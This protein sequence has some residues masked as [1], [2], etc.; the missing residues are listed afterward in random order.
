MRLLSAVCAVAL[1]AGLARA[2]EIPPTQLASLGWAMSASSGAVSS[3]GGAGPGGGLSG[4]L[5]VY[6]GCTAP[7]AA[8]DSYL[9]SK[10]WYFDVANGHPP[11]YYA[12]LAVPQAQ[13]GDVN[14]PFDNPNAIW[15]QNNI[16]GVQTDW[17]GWGSYTYPVAA[18]SL[19]VLALYGVYRTT[20]GKT[21]SDG[22]NATTGAPDFG[23]PAIH[24]PSHFRLWPGDT[25]Y[26][27][28]DSAGDSFGSVNFNSGSGTVAMIPNYNEDGSGNTKWVWIKADPNFPT[29]LFTEPGQSA[30]TIPQ[31]RGIIVQG[32][33]ALQQSDYSAL[34]QLGLGNLPSTGSPQGSGGPTGHANNAVIQ[35]PTT[36]GTGS[37]ATFDVTFNTS[38]Q[39]QGLQLRDPGTG[40]SNGD[41]LTPVTNGGIPTAN[42][43]SGVGSLTGFT[44]TVTAPNTILAGNGLPF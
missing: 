39:V 38:G 13:W 32:V 14:H 4:A 12:N 16:G 41:T 30:L 10:D 22:W 26:L 42:A 35:V 29:P 20:T 11:A 28:G 31:S 40:Y 44:I 8:P 21:T 25:V 7:P 5:A 27:R 23:N 1:C 19:H 17:P 33:N 3:G 6:A 9:S 43:P 18:N 37:G 15:G 2:N 24:D 36:G 34:T